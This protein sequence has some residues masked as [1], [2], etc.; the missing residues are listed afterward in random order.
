MPRW[1]CPMAPREI[2]AMWLLSRVCAWR[3]R[4]LSVLQAPSAAI[5]GGLREIG[6][7]D[8]SGPLLCLI[9]ACPAPWVCTF[10]V[11]EEQ[12]QPR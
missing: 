8:H 2:L 5:G 10:Q 3:L 7:G 9:R 11:S 12:E 4:G 6:D 1:R